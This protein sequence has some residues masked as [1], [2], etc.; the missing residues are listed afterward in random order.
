MIASAVLF[1]TP[2]KYEPWANGIP[3]AYLFTTEDNALPYPAQQG[4]AQQLGPGAKTAAVKA[5]HSPFLSVPLELVKA[6][7]SVL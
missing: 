5:G 3:C 1:A 7:E 2:A 4:M 6:I